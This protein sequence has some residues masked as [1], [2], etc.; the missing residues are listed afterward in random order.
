M[1][2]SDTSKK[3][4]Q[5][6]ND[7]IE[8]NE[9]LE[10]YFRNTIIPQLFVDSNLILRKYTPPAMKQFDFKEMHIG[11]SIEEL[12]DNIRYSTITENIKEVIKTGEVLE[13]EIQTTD[14]LWFQMNIIPYVIKKENKTNGVIITF[15][16]ITDRMQILKELESLNASHETFIYSV[17]HDLKAPMANIEGLVKLLTKSSDELTESMDEDTEDQ[18]YIV[19]L[20]DKSVKLMKDIIS[21]LTDIMKIKANFKEQVEPVNLE[22]IL[23]E[24]EMMLKDKINENKVTISY[25][26]QEQNVLFSRKNIRSILYNLISNGIKYHNPDK[27]PE[28]SVNIFKKNGLLHISVI[29]NGLGISK[30]QQKHIFAPFT[31]L[32]KN[33]EGTG[34]GLHLIK[35]IVENEGGRISFSS[36]A[37]QGTQ[38]DIELELKD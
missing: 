15:V 1:K 31:R 8:L 19:E 27:D 21:E 2:S 6:I 14:G 23:E 37:G 10:N 29:D 33:I 25:N 35:K 22:K 9:D 30:D 38:F 4:K 34:I 36:E 7:L 13:K 20:L 18:Q 16:D 32:K 24:I 11:K 3:A 26:I 12:T 17:S 28:V 5:K